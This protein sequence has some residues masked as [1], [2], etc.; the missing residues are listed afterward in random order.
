MVSIRQGLT[1]NMAIVLGDSSR[2]LRYMPGEPWRGK[3]P[4]VVTGW[5]DRFTG[6]IPNMG[7]QRGNPNNP[8][9][10]FYDYVDRL[11][12]GTTR[13][14]DT[15]MQNLDEWVDAVEDFYKFESHQ[16]LPGA[17]LV[18]ELLHSQLDP[19]GPYNIRSGE[20]VL[21][22]RMVVHLRQAPYSTVRDV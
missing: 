22:C 14:F 13:T 5:T 12:V 18:A 16:C 15:V 8:D 11:I 10:W 19:D 1:D 21:L 6:F 7:R 2:A 9:N 20:P 17:F 4:Y 3:W